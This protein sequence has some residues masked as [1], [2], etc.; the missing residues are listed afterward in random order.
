MSLC[1]WQRKTVVPALIEVVSCGFWLRFR[2]ALL[3]V[4]SAYEVTPVLEQ[5]QLALQNRT[6]M[7]GAR[8]IANV[9][10]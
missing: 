9:L 7:A 4:N 6:V 2:S 5:Q 1:A 8:E 10:A 3:R